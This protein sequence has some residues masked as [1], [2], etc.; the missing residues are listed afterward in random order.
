MKKACGRGVSIAF[1]SNALTKDKLLHQILF[2]LPLKY[3]LVINS[4]DMIAG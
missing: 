4:P 2:S 3:T 1:L